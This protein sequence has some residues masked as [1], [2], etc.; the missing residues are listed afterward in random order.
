M[1]E[2]RRSSLA[3]IEAQPLFAA[4]LCKVFR[5]DARFD[6]IGS[7]A[8]PMLE[9]LRVASP[10][11]IVVTMD[12]QDN[13]E[14][15]IQACLDALPSSLICILSKAPNP[16]AMELCLKAG[17]H[18]FMCTDMTPGE[19][20]HAV[21]AVASGETYVDPRAAGLVL[22]RHRQRDDARRNALSSVE[23]RVLRL[24]VEGLP[25]KLI[26]V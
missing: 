2:P 21:E 23:L 12:G 8:A 10:E 24:V 7:Y 15:C 4:V 18:A 3:V 5:Q 6:V 11:V 25:N 20:L 13:I 19:L 22:Q 14:S 26:A 17:A 16:E 1:P 9:A